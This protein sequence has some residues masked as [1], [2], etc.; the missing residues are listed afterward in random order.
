MSFDEANTDTYT[1]HTD[2]DDKL[3]EIKKG[4]V[5]VSKT[6]GSTPLRPFNDHA[7]YY[8]GCF[9]GPLVRLWADEGKVYFSSTRFLNAVDQFYVGPDFK[10]GP[11]F[12]EYGGETYVGEVFIKEGDTHIFMLS[13]QAHSVSSKNFVNDDGALVHLGIMNVDGTYTPPFKLVDEFEGEF[14]D[15]HGSRIYNPIS[16][17]RAKVLYG[18]FWNNSDIVIGLEEGEDGKLFPVKYCSEGAKY[19][20]NVCSGAPNVTLGLFNFLTQ[21]HRNTFIPKF[22]PDGCNSIEGYLSGENVSDSFAL[23]LLYRECCSSAKSPEVFAAYEDFLNTRRWLVNF[24]H[25]RQFE[26]THIDDERLSQHM[27][28]RCSDIS[29]RCETVGDVA[30][31]VR[32]EFGSS[33]YK[34]CEIRWLLED[35]GPI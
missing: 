1:I 22:F 31:F 27:N 20:S 12:T 30:K 16:P 18:R 35:N 28:K 8:L 17:G 23:A 4:D 13:D 26:R 25:T 3:G 5:V 24:I 34:F 33:L 21:D 29:G 32:R 10:F 19:R 2:K 14:V 11:L 7:K 9:E 15:Y 6:F